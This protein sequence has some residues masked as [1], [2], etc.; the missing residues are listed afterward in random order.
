MAKVK[1][2]KYNTLRE[3]CLE[4][5]NC[6]S[7]TEFEQSDIYTHKNLQIFKV[8]CPL[9]KH[10]WQ[11]HSCNVNIKTTQEAKEFFDSNS[12]SSIMWMKSEKLCK[13]SLGSNTIRQLKELRSKFLVN[14]KPI[15]E[16]D[17]SST[18]KVVSS[19]A[20]SAIWH[21]LVKLYTQ[22]EELEVELVE[23]RNTNS[24][25]S[26]TEERKPEVREV[27]ETLY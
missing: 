23:I 1:T 15:I 24:N 21:D 6:K 17:T 13:S 16:G 22:V 25:T 9:C 2:D 4:C 26:S 8:D 19:M 5:P 3:F 11:I 20:E 7:V 27:K 18:L 12:D 10:N 14:F